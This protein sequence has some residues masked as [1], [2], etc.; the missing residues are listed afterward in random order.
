MR[1]LLECVWPAALDAAAQPFKSATWVAAL[2]V[3]VARDDGNRGRTRAPTKPL[4]HD[5]S[6]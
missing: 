2:T 3:I 5:A 6:R 4:T 1:D